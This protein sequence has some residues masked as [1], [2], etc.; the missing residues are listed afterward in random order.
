MIITVD[1]QELEAVIC[2]KFGCKVY[3]VSHLKAHLERHER[4]AEI[5]LGRPLWLERS[6]PKPKTSKYMPK[7]QRHRLGS[8]IE[9]HISIRQ[10]GSYK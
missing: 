4:F 9:K 2:P 10:Y 5:A 8:T 6:A 1:G 7:P 3:P